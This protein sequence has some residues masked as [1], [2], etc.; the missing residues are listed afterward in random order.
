MSET[1]HTPGPWQIEEHE[2][3]PCRIRANNNGWDV[4][5]VF[6][7]DHPTGQANAA[8]IAAAPELLE[9]LRAML[10]NPNKLHINDVVE[11]HQRALDAIAKA[12]GRT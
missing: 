10:E 12:E 11:R 6:S 7:T 4:A 3:S 5:D 2:T 8:L 1:K 9:A